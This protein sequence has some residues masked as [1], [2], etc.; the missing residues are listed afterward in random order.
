MI[1]VGGVFERINNEIGNIKFVS[2]DKIL[3]VL[4]KNLKVASNEK[5]AAITEY[6]STKKELSL[7]STINLEA[8]KNGLTKDK[9]VPSTL[10]MPHPTLFKLEEEEKKEKAEN[11]ENACVYTQVNLVKP[12]KLPSGISEDLEVAEE[13]M[14]KDK[15]ELYCSHIQQ[16]RNRYTVSTPIERDKLSTSY[17]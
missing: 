14:E 10:A 13:F 12:S 9:H 3:R 5:E 1:V 6:I 16:D 7:R 8:K 2:D 4:V 11:A 15:V 17:K